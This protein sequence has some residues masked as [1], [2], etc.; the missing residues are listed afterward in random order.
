MK[1]KNSEDI[2]TIDS[3]TAVLNSSNIDEGYRAQ[4]STMRK[5]NLE[6]Y[7]DKV[8]KY[9]ISTYEKKGIVHFA[10][11]ISSTEKVYAKSLE[12]LYEKLFCHYSGKSLKDT[13]TIQSVF[14][15]A[16]DWHTAKKGNTGK[17][18]IRNQYT[19]DSFIKGTDFEK[20]P[21]K[22]I[23]ASDIEL[24][25]ISFKDKLTRKRLC[26]IKSI[27]NWVFEYATVHDIIP[28]NIA[29]G[30]TVSSVKT[31]PENNV[32]ELAYTYEE[33][34]RIVNHLIDSKSPYDEAICFNAYT[35]LRF[36]E[37]ADL[38]HD[39]HDKTHELLVVMHAYTE[40]GNIKN[41]DKGVKT[42]PLSKEAS[43]LLDR[44]RA[45]RPDSKYIFPNAAGNRISNNRLNEH[46]KKAC[47]ELG[48]PYRSNHKLRAY[49]ITQ[50]AYFSDANRARIMGGQSDIRTTQR[51]LSRNITQKDYDT[52]NKAFDYGLST[53]FNQELCNEK[54]S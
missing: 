24:F 36:S 53:N 37:I 13:A 50:V 49:F 31:I 30:I 23:K 17:T 34:Q 19:Y 52:V 7:I 10:T 22:D 44:Y 33:T 39:D 1:T 14:S 6:N 3:L 41:G 26:D 38:H 2:S 5:S 25:F 51:Y 32:G 21:L 28:Y 43:M 40:S 35:G 27:I 46:L 11:R 47:E 9:K 12:E 42:I 54:T 8:H 45:E 16:L 29:N 15:E 18:R 20:M 4:L 48:I